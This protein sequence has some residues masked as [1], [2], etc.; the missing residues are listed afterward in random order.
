MKRLRLGP[1]SQYA[2]GCGVG[3]Q[4]ADRR[5]AVFRHGATV[6]V[7]DDVCPHRGFPLHDGTLVGDLV[8]CRTHGSC[9]NL[10]TGAVER[11]PAAAGVRVY[12]VEIVDGEVEVEIP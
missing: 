1:L 9:F 2:D 8:R 5:F 10:K 3:V 12:H 11:G 7:V 4:I 6:Y